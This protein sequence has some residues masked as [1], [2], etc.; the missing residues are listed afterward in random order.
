MM[1]LTTQKHDYI[2]KSVNK[3]APF[4][5]RPNLGK[6]CGIMEKDTIQ[7]LSFLLPLNGGPSKSCKP[8]ICYKKPEGTEMRCVCLFM[9]YYHYILFK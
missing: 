1:S 9:Y 3:R 6:S 8:I 7:K 4:L 2:F 5:P